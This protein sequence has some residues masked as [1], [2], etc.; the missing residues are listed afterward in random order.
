MWTREM[1]KIM[2]SGGMRDREVMKE[3]SKSGSDIIRGI[4]KWYV[5]MTRQKLVFMLKHYYINTWYI[6][7]W[8]N[9]FK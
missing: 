6:R 8:E 1:N 9:M 4:R 3:V 7:V 2:I 5:I